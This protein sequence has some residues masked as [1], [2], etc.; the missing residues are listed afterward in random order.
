MFSVLSVQCIDACMRVCVCVCVCIVQRTLSGHKNI[1]SYIDSNVSK[2]NADV[3]E[4]L[5]L[6]QYCQG[7]VKLIA[8]DSL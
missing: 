7:I 3:Y 8:V 1:V 4:V 6:M 5:L 2:L